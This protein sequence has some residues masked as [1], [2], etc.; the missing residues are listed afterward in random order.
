M[1]E[2]TRDTAYRLV[3]DEEVKKRMAERIRAYRRQKGLSQKKLAE[4][5]GIM[6]APL[7]NIEKG[8]QIPTGR[9]LILLADQLQISV[10]DLLGR[11]IPAS[12]VE[13]AAP[14]AYLVFDPDV[15][16]HQDLLPY[17]EPMMLEDDL[18]HTPE[19]QER[20]E[21]IVRCYLAL[22]D[23][24][25]TT[26]RAMIPLQAAFTR[27]AAGMDVLSRMVRGYLGIGEGVIFDYLELIE[28]AG[29]RVVFCEL[30]LPTQSVAYYDTVNGNAFIFV[31]T[32]M[33][34]E[35]QL[36][37]LVKRLGTIYLHTS[38]VPASGAAALDNLHAVR[39]FTACFLMPETAVRASVAQLGIAP[40]AWTYPLALRLKH[41]FGVS[42]QS[43]VYRLL[44]LELVTPKLAEDF[45]RRIEDHY[46][47]R[48][49]KEPEGTKRVLT[50]NGRLG[51]IAL[52]ARST[53]GRVRQV[54]EIRQMLATAGVKL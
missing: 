16:G 40:D 8:R 1:N 42:A 45:R 30:P 52:V 35:R 5:M 19:L 12:K 29:L 22:E 36:F 39:K 37:E 3:A 41:R 31:H 34:P 24:C 50:P 54:K 20:L 7:N 10:D 11:E 13:P 27:T 6:P 33:N 28:N 49:Y 53:P 43:F 9:T 21:T 47:R 32:D 51:D 48:D 15:S 18:R 38:K 17:A 26:K 23:Y 2:V 46:W 4:M 14:P 25:G 44:E